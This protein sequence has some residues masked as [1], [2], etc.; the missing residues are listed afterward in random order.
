MCVLLWKRGF[1]VVFSRKHMFL[2]KSSK[3]SRFIDCLIDC[4]CCLYCS[5]FDFIEPETVELGEIEDVERDPDYI[6][7]YIYMSGTELHHKYANMAP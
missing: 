5:K 7:L 1:P 2:T 4:F 6:P 3:M